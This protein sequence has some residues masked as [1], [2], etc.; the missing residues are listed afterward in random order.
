MKVSGGLIGITMNVSARNRFFLVSP[1]LAKL[2]EEALCLNG[3][4]QKKKKHHKLQPHV[5]RRVEDRINSLTEVMRNHE[6]PF[7]T[8]SN[9]LFNLVTKKVLP[10]EN[11]KEICQQP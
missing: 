1:Y 11:Q 6:N 2:A 5:Q 4:Q 7:Q 10:E 9:K 8:E 3:Q